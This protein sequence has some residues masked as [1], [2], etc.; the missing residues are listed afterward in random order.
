MSKGIGADGMGRRGTPSCRAKG[1]TVA[2]IDSGSIRGTSRS[3]TDV[4]TVD[5]TGGDGIDHFGRHARGDHRRPAGRRPTRMYQ[6]VAS[7]AYLLNLRVLGNDGSGRRATSST[8]L[9][10]RHRQQYNASGS[11]LVARRP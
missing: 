2:V 6:G 8:R 5:F 3:R 10:H 11:E 9:G 7:G 4:A 1:V